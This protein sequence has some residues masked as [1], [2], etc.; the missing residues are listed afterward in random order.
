VP[1]TKL[2][3]KPGVVKDTTAYSN[4][5]GWVDSDKVRFRFG[6]PEKLGGWKNKAPNGSFVGT[7]RS[8][9]AWQSLDG[10]PFVGLGTHKKYFIESGE[11]FNNITP[12]RFSVMRPVVLTGGFSVTTSLGSVTV[13][14]EPFQSALLQAQ[15]GLGSVTILFS[16]T[17]SAGVP[18]SA[19]LG[20]VT[21]STS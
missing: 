2:Q 5:G 4:E 3:F 10:V 11:I 15:G 12:I 19:L 16:Q 9:H 14:T 17:L 20:N 18:A 7:P 8:L 13:T 6:Y 1:L 21:V